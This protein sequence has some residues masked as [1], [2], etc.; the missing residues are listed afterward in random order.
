ML[1]KTAI[2]KDAQKYL[3][4]GAIDKAISE[5]ERLVKDSP[6]GNTYN[7]IGDIY[8]RKGVTLS[9]IEN[10]QKA[11]NFFRTEGFTQKAQ[12]LC[13][14]IININPANTD[15]LIVFGEICEEKGMLAEAIKY[16]LTV[17]DL[18]AKEG[19]KE[20]ILDVY[21]KILSLSPVNIP[22]RAKVA[23]I[24]LKEGLKTNAAHEFA[25]IA[26]IHDEKGDIPKARE[27]FQ[28]T[29]DIQPLNKD[30]TLGLSHI[31]E[32][33]G[34]IQ[35][36]VEQMKDA[37][38]L[39]PED[40]DILFRCTD[41]A[42]TSDETSL[43]EKCLQRIIEKE[44]KNIKARIM[45]GE[46]YLK[47]GEREFAWAQ[48]LP[49]L[50]EVLL[51]QK[52]E[53]AI[54]FLNTFRSIEP[55]ETGKRLVS[56]Y[57]QLNEDDRAVTE[58]IAIG[59]V[60]AEKG[61]DDDARSC[62]AEAEQINPLHAELRKRIA[63]PESE[64]IVE[65]SPAPEVEIPEILA[66]ESGIRETVI[67]PEAPSMPEIIKTKESAVSASEGPIVEQF[68]APVDK[69]KA[70]PESIT[71]R[72][73]KAFDEVIT[74]ADIFFR[75]GLLGE[76]QRLLEDLKQRFP[77]NI[78]VHLRLKS[79]YADTHNSKALVSECLILNELYKRIGDEANAEQ[80]LKDAFELSP[81]D[82][83]LAE[84]GFTSFFEKP[85]FTSSQPTGF[86]E[87]AS[88]KE[89]DI[90]DY[91]EEIAEADFYAR[92]G[93]AAEAL[94]ILEKLQ[95][96]FPENSDLRERLNALRHI[97]RD[98]E[99]GER[100]EG[101]DT[102]DTFNILE[103]VEAPTEFELDETVGADEESAVTSGVEQ[104]ESN[105]LPDM[106]TVFDIFEEPE[107]TAPLQTE[108]SPLE[109]S[110]SIVTGPPEENEFE[111]FD[112]SDDDLED[113]QV[114]P[115]PSL[116]NDVLEIFQEFKKGL[117][118]ELG[119]E[120]SE[121]HYNLGIAYK[122]MGLVDDAIKEFQTSRS[123]PAR[124]IQSSTMLGV[125]YMEQG[126]YSLAIDVLSKAV[127]EMKERDDSYWALTYELAEAYE[128]NRNLKEALDLYTGVY[129][130]SAKFRDVSDKMSL[131]RAQ[132]PLIIE[133]EKVKEKPKERKDRVS[134][135]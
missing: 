28:K 9:A 30:A 107:K 10:Y 61:L 25:H 42:I 23:D 93:L 60:Y 134:Y 36:A 103:D 95:E 118:K 14:K 62:Y 40:L 101:M 81:E 106:H 32:K 6:D 20:K 85:S 82:P 5:L 1:D 54:S 16:Y 29:L 90:D 78:D 79:V 46:Q 69:K 127:S 66:G 122:E 48:Y 15:A 131:L 57:K 112:L 110:S 111:T 105:D 51:D 73:E 94:K 133:K 123:D 37:M 70:R 91:E 39:F 8:L 24:Y 19:I 97:D 113:A 53:D 84:Q 115:E 34:E 102:Y 121:T 44:P 12:A 114:M 116:D 98:R 77:E 3:A 68:E 75:Y 74:E 64:P 35:Q 65:E 96:L 2:L 18:L 92:Q 38:V 86:G 13:K 11:A 45:L 33:T 76:A 109:E 63:P 21:A 27:F 130:W 22:L 71:V 47:A 7:M 124:F 49:I 26:R 87:D 59:D 67:E 126:L 88:S 58:L 135:L 100:A 41:L 31:Y 43:A 17:A 72:V 4:K 129:G 55:I 80:A 56:L 89:L 119:D 117:N 99:G 104:Q 132:A 108:L 125:C 52:F 50:D 83:R 128:K 120:D